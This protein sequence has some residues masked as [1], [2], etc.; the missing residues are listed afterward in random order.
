MKKEYTSEELNEFDQL[1]EEI[2]ILFAY[3]T[4]DK[5]FYVGST[6]RKA[7]DMGIRSKQLS[8]EKKNDI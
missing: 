5:R 3:H 1:V 2:G 4:V 8:G 7:Y 6:L